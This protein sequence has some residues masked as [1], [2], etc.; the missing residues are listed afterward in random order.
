[1]EMC[2]VCLNSK[3]LGICHNCS[4]FQPDEQLLERLTMCKKNLFMWLT[5]WLEVGWFSDGIADVCATINPQQYTSS[6]IFVRSLDQMT[7]NP[8]LIIIQHTVELIHVKL[9]DGGIKQRARSTKVLSENNDGFFLLVLCILMPVLEWC[10][11]L[12]LQVNF[13]ITVLS[14]QECHCHSYRHVILASWPM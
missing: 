13:A 6:K 11:R 9:Q 3:G 5:R 2:L 1:M 10:V 12:Q 8:G 4:N 7:C 14:F